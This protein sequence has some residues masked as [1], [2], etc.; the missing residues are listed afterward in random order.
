MIALLQGKVIHLSAPMAIIATNAGIGYEVEL[1]V[2]SFCQLQ[3]NQNAEIWTYQHVREDANLLYGFS[4]H[5]DRELFR[6]LLKINGVG[7]KMALAILSTLSVVELKQCVDNDEVA[8]LTRISGIGKKTAQRLLIELKDK[9]NDIEILATDEPI[10]ETNPQ[11]IKN[12][13]VTETKSALISL[14]YK[15][16]EAEQAIKLVQKQTD[17]SYETTQ[18]LLKASLQQLA[19]GH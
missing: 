6:Q 19:R 1:T 18:S 7:A 8:T 15:E 10:S 11:N 2:P 3:L 14:G 4:T 12:Q 13:I 16:K 17:T 9:L 5:R